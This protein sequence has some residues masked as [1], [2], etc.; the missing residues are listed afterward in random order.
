MD[1]RCS[2]KDLITNH[3]TFALYN[4]AAI[5]PDQAAERWPQAFFTNGHTTINAEKMSKSLGNFLTLSECV[6]QFSADAT[7]LALADAGD[8][9][10]DANFAADTCNAAIMKLC[11]EEKWIEEFISVKKKKI[12]KKKKKKKK[13]TRFFFKCGGQI[14]WGSVVA[15][16][17]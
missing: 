2:G 10:E 3:L 5:W 8:G 17:I 16:Y 7:R 9:L 11:R 13:T 14:L 1:L 6:D 15:V 12:N 4:H